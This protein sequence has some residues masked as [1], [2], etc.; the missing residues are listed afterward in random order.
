MSKDDASQWL[1]VF[2]NADDIE[3]WI[4][5]PGSEKLSSGLMDY[6]PKSMHGHVVF[7]TRDRKTAVK[8]AQ[9]NIVEVL[10]MSEGIATQLLHKSLL[11]SDLLS[12][13]KN[14]QLL[15][16]ELT[17]LPLA[18]V[19]AAAYINENDILLSDYLSL[20]KEQEEDVIDLLSEDFEDDWRYRNI[21]NPVA[22]TWL[23]S[24]EQVRRRDPLAADYLSFMSCVDPRG[25]PQS[26]LP[27]ELSRKKEHDAIGTLTAYSFVSRRPDLALDLHRLVHLATRNWLRMEELATQT[28]G[29][30]MVRLKEM[31]SADYHNIN[32]NRSAWRK[33][34]PHAR[35]ALDSDSIE[36]NEEYRVGLM[37]R[38]GRCL[39]LEGRW[40]EAEISFGQV[41]KIRTRLLGMN[42]SD[43]LE[44]V[45]SLASTCRKQGRWTEAEE[46]CVQVLETKK[47]VLG[48]EHPDALISAGNLALTYCN[49]GRWTE[50]EELEVQVLETIQRVLGEEHPDTLIS[51]ANL[52]S[53]YTIQGRWAEAEELEVQV[54]ETKKRVLTILTPWHVLK[55]SIPGEQN[56]YS[57]Y[58]FEMEH[59]KMYGCQPDRSRQNC[60][61]T[62][63]TVLSMSFRG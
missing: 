36:A 14:T 45:E 55:H 54:L 13:Q 37:W 25:I 41:V 33:Y 11:N 7:T 24:F 22:T 60:F 31:F 59:Y 23:I 46:L 5:K 51:I 32:R 57:F 18:I 12:D 1:L 56:S 63:N 44:S 58:S 48:E 38:Y 3:M 30:V 53:T 16:T 9:P 8:L 21:K 10:E 34:M 2:D 50:A 49:Q 62:Y 40:N 4:T 47:R 17:Y 26:L 19:Q 42:H 43:T 15:L 29:G 52:A 27:S 6:L 39:N 20:L 61:L 28:M 35:Y